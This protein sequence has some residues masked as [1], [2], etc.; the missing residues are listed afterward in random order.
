MAAVVRS[1]S[2]AATGGRWETWVLTD[3]RPTQGPLVATAE[4]AGTV[5]DAL[6]RGALMT[7]AA[8]APDPANSMIRHLA[9]AGTLT[10]ADLDGMLGARLTDEDRVA[11]NAQNTPPQQLVDILASAGAVGPATV[12]AV[13][14]HE[15]VDGATVAFAGA[16]GP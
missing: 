8:A 13:L 15:G 12:I 3:G 14:H 4:D 1:S 11:L 2:S 5:A 6:G 10:R 16:G 9:D 7:L